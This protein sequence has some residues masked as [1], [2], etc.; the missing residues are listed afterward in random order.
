MF[1]PGLLQF[2]NIEER[3]RQ[4][5]IPFTIVRVFFYTVSISINSSF[6]FNVN[7][8]AYFFLFSPFLFCSTCTL[9]ESPAVD[10]CPI[11]G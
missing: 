5:D 11:Q 6:F 4:S 10:Q 7:G 9:G 1:A 2:A 3:V 8:S